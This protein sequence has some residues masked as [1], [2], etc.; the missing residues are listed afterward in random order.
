[1]EKIAP[2]L[3]VRINPALINSKQIEGAL[4]EIN[5]LGYFIWV[6]GNLKT[7]EIEFELL[8]T[9]NIEP[10]EFEE[11]KERFSKEL[12]I[13]S[14]L[15]KVEK[16][17]KF[18]KESGMIADYEV[19]VEGNYSFKP[20]EAIKNQ[21]IDIDMIPSIMREGFEGEID[22]ILLSTRSFGKDKATE[23]FVEQIAADRTEENEE[24]KAEL[25][26]QQ[27]VEKENREIMGGQKRFIDK[28]YFKLK[29]SQEVG[30]D[31][32]YFAKGTILEWSGEATKSRVEQV[33]C[34]KHVGCKEIGKHTIFTFKSDAL[35]IPTD[36]EVLEALEKSGITVEVIIPEGTDN[37]DMQKYL[38]RNTKMKI[39]KGLAEDTF[40]L[41]AKLGVYWR[42]NTAATGTDDIE[43]DLDNCVYA[44][45]E[46]NKN[47]NRCAGWLHNSK[48]AFEVSDLREI[49]YNEDE[50]DN[51][52]FAEIENQ[53]QRNEKIK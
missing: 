1:M 23:I 40:A 46:L 16:S 20:N 5:N 38:I 37:A 7:E 50:D 32:K 47:L 13:S 17:L 35:E 49:F 48:E 15:S 21:T 42:N 28:I 14:N 22:N 4:E 19:D 3:I 12:S 53:R 31:A 18:L 43:F 39:Y 30:Y 45:I 10:I 2:I 33:I 26:E 44:K 6:I 29:E 9:Y 25:E 36:E 11:I 51:G 8:A 52:Y 41:L 34:L 27:K 24:L